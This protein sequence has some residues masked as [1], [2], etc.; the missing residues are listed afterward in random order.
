[1]HRMI[2]N[3]TMHA[4]LRQTDERTKHHSNSATIRSNERIARLKLFGLVK[5]ANFTIIKKNKPF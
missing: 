1:M 3:F 5:F 4:H 2:T